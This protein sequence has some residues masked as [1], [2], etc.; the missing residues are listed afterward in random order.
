MQR[1]QK[2]E[3]EKTKE[4]ETAKKEEVKVEQNAGEATE[5][6]MMAMMGFGDFST[7]KNKNHSQDAAEAV[8]K[9]FI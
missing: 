5:E 7:T 8:Y 4:A 3:A 9:S 2:R 1:V 6:A